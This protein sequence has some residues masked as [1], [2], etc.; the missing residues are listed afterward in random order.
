[1][2]KIAFVFATAAM[3]AACTGNKPQE[4]AQEATEPAATTRV[5]KEIP[6]N[7]EE[8]QIK[9]GM[10]VQ[11]DSLTACWLRVGKSPV[12]VSL[13]QK[14]VTLSDDQ[15]KVKPD[16]LMNPAEIM[17]KLESLSLKYRALSVLAIDKGVADAYEMTDVYSEPVSKLTAEI[18]DPAMSYIL[19]NGSENSEVSK[20]YEI[21]EQN[22]RANYFW[23][24]A[25][26]GI[27]EQLYVLT[28]NQDMFLA[29][30]TDKDAEDITY[31]VVLLIEAYE[32]LSEYNLEL[33]KL[34]NVLLPLEALD[35]ITV[36]QLRE[37][38]GQVQGQVE[39]ARAAL[40]L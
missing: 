12:Q 40:F 13:E 2:K 11:L 21:E 19:E 29:N 3:L 39:Q 36:D 15:K 8:Q 22:G 6:E 9:A 7:F 28:K 38:L 32:D 34:Y 26:T 5:A 31:R 1:M 35:A 37:Q 27:I 23:E 14:S 24:S 16:Y 33:R 10:S 17:D 25:A 18:N 20:I 4:P 30:F